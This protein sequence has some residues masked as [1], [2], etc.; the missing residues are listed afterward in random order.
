MTYWTIPTEGEEEY[1]YDY[2]YEYEDED[3]VETTPMRP[4]IRT[5][6][7]SSVPKLE[8]L[9]KPVFKPS[10]QTIQSPPPTTTSLPKVPVTVPDFLMVMPEED[11]RSSMELREPVRNRMQR[12]HF[13]TVRTPQRDI[14][15][16]RRLRPVMT[17]QRIQR[18][19]KVGE[20]QLPPRFQT[21][22]PRFTLTSL[23][24]LKSVEQ[25]LKTGPVA[26]S[27]GKCNGRIRLLTAN[28]GQLASPNFGY[29]NYFPDDLCFW[30]IIAPEN[31]RIRLGFSFLMLQPDSGCYSDFLNIYDGASETG[32]LIAAFC[33]AKSPPPDREILTNGN[34]AFIKFATDSVG[35]F[36]GFQV[37]YEFFGNT[38]FSH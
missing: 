31:K 3:D 17:T 25:G 6:G 2:E 24:P 28:S 33:G 16:F 20:P 37:G 13:A 9:V 34:T 38:F 4:I 14:Y 35:E 11:F 12:N 10:I 29:G 27:D 1:E 23:R 7:E 26:S 15:P 5:I 36:P 22:P 19:Q 30:Q 21:E 8:P 32:P 18:L